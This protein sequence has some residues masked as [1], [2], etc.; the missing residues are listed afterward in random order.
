M[1]RAMLH[2]ENQLRIPPRK[3]AWSPDLRKA[4]LLFRYWK[5]CLADFYQELDSYRTHASIQQRLQQHD[6]RYQ[7][8]SADDMTDV[9]IRHEI[10]QAGAHLRKVRKTHLESRFKNLEELLAEYESDKDP[11]TREESWRK[12]NIVSNTIRTE[13]IRTMFRKIG[14]AVKPKQSGGIKSSFP[15]I[16]GRCVSLLPWRCPRRPDVLGP[17]SRE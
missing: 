8:P 14:H 11:L 3:Y 9:E 5:S 17:F 12:A 13:K 15:T 7:L 4:G 6:R 10:S 16:Q 2:A 1:G